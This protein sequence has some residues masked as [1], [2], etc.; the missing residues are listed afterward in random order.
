MTGP[1][2][3]LYVVNFRVISWERSEI[4]ARSKEHAAFRVTQHVTKEREGVIDVAID[5]VYP[6]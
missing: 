4:L 1:T 3:L 5:R 6:K 2:E